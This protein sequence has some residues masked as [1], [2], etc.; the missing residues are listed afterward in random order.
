M[1]KFF[2]TVRYDAKKLDVQMHYLTM[3]M[4]Y[5]IMGT[6]WCLTGLKKR[7][8]IKEVFL[9]SIFDGEIRGSEAAGGLRMS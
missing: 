6:K 7:I 9:L 1:P 5:L 2:K 4:R 3:W 8:E